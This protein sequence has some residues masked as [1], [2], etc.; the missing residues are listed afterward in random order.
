M[1]R[2]GNLEEGRLLTTGEKALVVMLA[3]GLFGY[4]AGFNLS[5]PS[6]PDPFPVA[7]AAAQQPLPPAAT[8]LSAAGSADRAA[9]A[10]AQ[11]ADPPTPAF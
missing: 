1:K 9:A 6:V 10:S 7:A 5:A 3:A 4:W 8:T 2:L 11:R